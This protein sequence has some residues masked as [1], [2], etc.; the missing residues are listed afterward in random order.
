QHFV[1]RKRADVRQYLTTEDGLG[2]DS[3]A[4]RTAFPS[5]RFFKDET[6]KLSPAYRALLDD[7]IA[8]ASERVEA[9]GS[10]GKR[11]ARI[12][13]WSAIALLRSLV[14][15]PRAAAQTLRTRSA[16]AAAASAEEA[17]RFGAPLTRDAADSDSLEGMDVAPGAP[18]RPR[19]GAGRPGRRVGPE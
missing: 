12:A 1:Q 2:D 15:S 6:Y 18:R 8:Y 3:L 5:D 17:D 9:A 11:E 13:W 14:S 16:A 7:A 4:E 19:P 10:Q